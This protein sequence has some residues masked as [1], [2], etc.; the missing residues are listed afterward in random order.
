MEPLP[1]LRQIKL[2]RDQIPDSNAYP[3]SLPVVKAL[4]TLE[5]APGV[6]FLV[7]ENGSGK[8]T[9]MEAIAVGMGFNP[10]GGTK[11][12]NFESRATHS[13]L[14]RFLAFTKSFKQPKDGFFL[15][16][17]SFYNV[18]TH[19]DQLDEQDMGGLRNVPEVK[20]SYGGLSLH[21]QSHGESFLSLFVNRFRGRGLYLL[22]E[23][24]AALSPARQLAV[25]RRMHELVAQETQLIVATH[26][27]ILLA[28][29]GAVIYQI[30]DDG[31]N[32]VSYEETEHLQL[33]RAFLNDP[34]IFLKGLF[35]DT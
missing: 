27:P 19:I 16:A 12:F 7:G 34:R 30:D 1:Y 8:S 4:D 15:R 26:S 6:T 20:G 23:P 25:L 2:K 33:S 22:D 29:P 18:A 3:F 32:R 35:D 11:N 21:R 10:E 17:E 31:L 24:E 14:N 9:L 5:F 28:Y 13:E